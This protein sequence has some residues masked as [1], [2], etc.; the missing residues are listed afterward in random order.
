MTMSPRLGSAATVAS[1]LLAGTVVACSDT[2]TAN[3]LIP[4][5]ASRG[6]VGSSSSTFANF[7]PLADQASCV[8]PPSTLGEFAT[9]QPFNLPQGYS[10]TIIADEVTDFQPVA[11]SGAGNPD[12]N[13][14]N[15]TGPE[16]G[17]FLYR[18]HEVGSN[19]AVTVFDL[20]TGTT[21]LIAQQSHYEALDGIAWTPWGTVIFAEERVVAALKDPAVPNAVGGLLYEYDPRTGTTVPRPAFG[22]RSHEGLRFDS[23]GNLYGI[24]ESTLGVNGAGAIYKFVPDTKGD[25]SSGQLYALKVL[26]GSRT[27]AAV[28][29]PLDRQAVQVNSDNE[30]IAAGATGWGRPEDVEIATSTGN[31]RGGVNVMYIPATSESLVLKIELS[32]DQAFVTNYVQEGMNVNGLSSPDNVALDHQGNLFILEDNSPGDIWVARP[33]QGS[34]DVPSEVVRFASLTD[35]SAEPTG[36]YFDRSGTILY[37]H[38]QH[39]GGVLGN[40][41]LVAITRD[42]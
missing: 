20:W 27:G 19:G 14:L 37:I 11:G 7:T 15:E 21:S 30:A 10:Q 36:A 26:S 24:S 38:V 16:A 42:N 6:V 18:T 33:R 2:P 13:T 29:V 31:N 28:W 22:A 35:C 39:A 1:L 3:R 17:R 41:L 9:Y 40:D 5:S 12:M 34:S 32:G 23:Q 25:L 8:V 4:S